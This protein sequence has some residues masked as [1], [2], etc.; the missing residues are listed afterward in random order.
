MIS[1]KM[2][3]AINDQI[4]AEFD[5]AFI[6]LGMSAYFEDSDLPGMAHWMR[7]QYEE[8]V[9]HAEKFMDHLYERGATVKIQEVAK[10]KE[11]YDGPLDVFKETL[12]HEQ[13]VTALIHKLMDLAVEE[14][15]YA[16]QS[17]LQWFIDEQVEEEASV[18][19]IIKSLELLG[20]SGGIY[21]L[22][23]ELGRRSGDDD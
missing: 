23:R 1:K 18:T 8:E 4:K 17:M 7:K 3:A 19:A 11:K 12:K 16:T 14:K 22:D 15:D 13:H 6:Y 5:S 21:M 10:P 9:E 20:G 2:V